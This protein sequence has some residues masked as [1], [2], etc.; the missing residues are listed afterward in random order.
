[1][2]SKKKKNTIWNKAAPFWPKDLKTGFTFK[3][4]LIKPT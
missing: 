4:F 1:M 3:N 2:G